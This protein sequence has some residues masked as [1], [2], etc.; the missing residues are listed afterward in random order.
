MPT[1]I[2]TPEFNSKKLRHLGLNDITPQ[3]LPVDYFPMEWFPS[4][5]DFLP[6][7]MWLRREEKRS[8]SHQAQT[9]GAYSIN[10]MEFRLDFHLV[11]GV[12]T[13][14]HGNETF[15]RSSPLP[16]PFLHESSTY[17]CIAFVCTHKT[18]SQSRALL[19]IFNFENLM[20]LGSFVKSKSNLR[21]AS[22][23]FH[24]SEAQKL[25]AE[26]RL[27]SDVNGFRR[28]LGG[29]RVRTCFELI[30]WNLKSY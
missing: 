25:E 28:E 4:K 8:K 9:I 2:D 19:K 5:L 10:F 1:K 21:G 14:L 15:L 27:A 18:C 16:P 11:H 24:R 20:A 17:L 3:Q 13:V 30:G 6:S 29:E 22:R 23:Y 12:P 7:A 26:S